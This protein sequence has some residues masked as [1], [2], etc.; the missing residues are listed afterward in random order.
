M[1][2]KPA[3]W[4]KYDP[5]MTISKLVVQ[6][7]LHDDFTIPFPMT[8]TCEWLGGDI[9]LEI[10]RT[11]EQVMAIYYMSEKTAELWSDNLGFTFI[12]H[13]WQVIESTRG[14]RPYIAGIVFPRETPELLGEAVTI[15]FDWLM[16]NVVKTG[17]F[18]IEGYL[19]PTT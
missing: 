2:E 17:N 5:E 7:C 4:H 13:N 19:C 11:E 14:E 9:L 16:P 10:V 18:A 12:D 15:S 6:E 8:L 3:D 1:T